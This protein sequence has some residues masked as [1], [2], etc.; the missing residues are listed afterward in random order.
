MGN[1]FYL[2][3]KAILEQAAGRDWRVLVRPEMAH[4]RSEW[5]ESDPALIDRV[6]VGFFDRRVMGFHQAYGDDFTSDQND[7]FCTDILLKRLDPR[8]V[9]DD[10]VVVNV[11]RGDYYSDGTFRGNYSF[12]VREYLAEAMKVAREL[13]PV[14]HAILVSDD[15]QWCEI[16]VTPQ[17]LAV[18]RVSVL[19]ASGP[20]QALE[21]LAGAERL[22]LTNSTFSYWG[23]YLSTAVHRSNHS[24]VIAPRF[25]SR[26]VR[27]G[28]AWQLD[29]RWTV[30]EDIPGGWDG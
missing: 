30:I 1:H 12:D 22:I 6:D 27:G 5:P 23:A 28:R 11:R 9:P 3:Q 20:I 17:L 24:A 18:E 21:Q 2:W 7:R 19:T 10:T 16:K 29:P 13:A 4:W 25:H 26:A 14:R 15:P 8:P